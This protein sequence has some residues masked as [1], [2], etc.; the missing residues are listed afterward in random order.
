MMTLNSAHTGAGVK[1]AENPKSEAR[2][3]KQTKSELEN[4]GMTQTA[5]RWPRVLL[6]S[7]FTIFGI[8]FGFRASDFEFP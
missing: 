5:L 6:I 4:G 7:E 3:P 1:E 2:N 8:C